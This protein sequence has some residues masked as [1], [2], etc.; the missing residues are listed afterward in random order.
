MN[1]EF[2][3]AD[4]L[5]VGLVLL[6]GFFKLP[7]PFMG[8]QALSLLMAERL[9]DGGV[10]YRDLWDL[11]HPGIFVFYF[12]GGSAFGFTE[13]GIHAFELLYMSAF[14]VT[15]V[16]ATRD[17]FQHR[18]VA[19]LSPLLVVGVYYVVSHVW[20]QTQTESVVGF[21]LFLALA[22]RHRA[23]I[24]DGAAARWLFASGLA[25]GIAL[26]FKFV[27]LPIV[28]AFWITG[29]W[30][31]QKR[32]L[33]RPA[34]AVVRAGLPLLAG[35]ALPLGAILIYLLRYDLLPLAAWTFV[36]YPARAVAEVPPDFGMLSTGARWFAATFAPL[37]PLAAVGAYV[38]CAGRRFLPVNLLLWLV[39][40]LGVI[41]I[42][43]ISWWPYH[44]LLLVTPVGLLAAVGID[45][46]WA[47]VE[48]VAARGFRWPVRVGAALLLALLLTPLIRAGASIARR[49]ARYGYGIREEQRIA[50]QKRVSRDYREMASDLDFLPAASGRPRD[51]YVFGDP[52]YYY[53]A[54]RQP[55]VALMATWFRALPDVWV[56]LLERIDRTRP[57]YIF[58]SKG[59]FAEVR[60]EAPR[61]IEP[62][63]ERTIPFIE[64]RYQ[65]HH[66]SPGGTWYILRTRP[67][68]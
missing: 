52:L 5:V 10:M 43:R 19:S 38:A 7:H 27:L 30:E 62:L 8:D 36:T 64:A 20:H 12:L 6:L 1:K 59:A 31:R 11:K 61:G 42:Q 49:S 9:A 35:A 13:L 46:M 44:Y 48:R 60:K 28:L 66:L 41:L 22:C 40:G 24:A 16:W 18:F 47:R 15:L 29:E 65:L 21:P 51:L 23:L 63:L 25:A 58:M 39:L 45:A 26:C 57:T 54:R 50:Y 3:S 4:V 53:L 56:D 2:R 33:G 67:A 14:A 68:R 34:G 17:L 55:P 37:L 32:E